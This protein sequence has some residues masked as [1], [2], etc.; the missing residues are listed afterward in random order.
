MV[1]K[2][3]LRFDTITFYFEP[4]DRHAREGNHNTYNACLRNSRVSSG[5]SKIERE[6]FASGADTLKFGG[7]TFEKIEDNAEV[8]NGESMI[9]RWVTY[10]LKK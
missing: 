8:A 6:L 3:K 2:N 7:R 1:T 4:K 5:L 9:L 10:K